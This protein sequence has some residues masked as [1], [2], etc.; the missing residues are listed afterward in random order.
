MSSSL[1]P[2]ALSTPKPLNV[3]PLRF[4]VL[5]LLPSSTTAVATALPVDASQATGRGGL[6]ALPSGPATPPAPPAPVPAADGLE[7]SP[8][9]AL[10]PPVANPLPPVPSVTPP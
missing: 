6:P 5:T 3:R 2:L 10:D 7:L 4:S 9:C 8:A 1:V